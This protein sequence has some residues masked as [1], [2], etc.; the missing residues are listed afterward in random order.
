VIAADRLQ[1]FS[2]G[3]IGLRRGE[4]GLSPYNLRWK[5]LFSDEAHFIFDELRVESL[6]LYH[7]GSTSVQGLAAKPIIDMLGSVPS[8]EILDRTKSSL[9]SV[10]YEYKGEYGVKGR[11]YCVLYNPE[12][13]TACVHLH[14]FQHGDPE[15]ERHLLFRDDLRKLPAAREEYLRVKRHLIEDM[16]VSREKYSDAKSEIIA[17]IQNEAF[18][19]RSPKKI[20]AVLGAAEGHGGTLKFLQDTYASDSLEVVDLNKDAI[21]PFCY[22]NNAADGFQKII[23][24]ALEADLVVLATPVYW[25]A[26]SGAMK[27]FMDRFSNLMSGEHKSLGESLYGKK[28]HLLSTGYDLRLPM[29]FEVPFSSTAIYFGMDYMGA[30]YRSVR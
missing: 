1:K 3:G 8:L 13:T 18:H 5:R 16:K 15:V 21:R 7:V 19:N 30:T 26:M 14:F 11:R 10:G 2:D 4:L 25:Y 12:K 6:R 29:G 22:G 24:K 17:K 20:L 9:E 23:V 27:D 28:V